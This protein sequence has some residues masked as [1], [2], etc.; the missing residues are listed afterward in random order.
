MSDPNNDQQE[1]EFTF[2]GENI[3]ISFDG[4][5]S[6]DSSPEQVVVEDPEGRTCSRCGEYYEYAHS[7]QPDGTFKCWGCRH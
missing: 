5:L 4:D 7:N 2:E 1:L 3:T 6:G